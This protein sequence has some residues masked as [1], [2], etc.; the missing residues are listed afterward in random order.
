MLVQRLDDVARHPLEKGWHTKVDS[1]HLFID[2][3]VQIWEDTKFEE[4]HLYGVTAY[5][6]TTFRP[7]DDSARA[8]DAIAE[9]WRI[10]REHPTVRLALTAA[11]IEAA[12]AKKQAAIIIGS[13]GGDFLGQELSLLEMFHRLGLRVMIPA[14][15][16]RTPLADGCLEPT[17]AGLSRM[18]RNWVA[19]CNRV[20]MLIDC[21]H[22][23]E[24]SVL[25]IMELTG[26]PVC[27]THSNPK[28]LVD[29]PRNITDE[30]I[31]KCAALGGVIGQTS[32]A[33]LL[34]KP[35]HNGRPTLGDFIDAVSYVA[36]LVG[37]DHVG[38]G[39]DMSH[40]TYPDG[41]RMRG[42]KLGGRFNELVEPNPRSRLRAVDGFDTWGQIPDVARA[43]EARG[44][45][46][47]EVAKILGGNW[48]RLFRTVWGG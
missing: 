10:A 2:T 19:E 26:Q 45:S 46:N 21:T 43:F 14:Y 12:H 41:E 33:P 23:G 5:L 39:T 40:G 18:G 37:V 38:I 28:R 11:D 48:L 32:W 30:V 3:C 4:L 9:W 13:Q 6:Q 15:N 44:F 24:R 20:G 34:L 42:K 27:F 35:E 29:S 25:D 1:P 17:N 47:E 8:L 16:A 31:R 22:V 36:D 7:H